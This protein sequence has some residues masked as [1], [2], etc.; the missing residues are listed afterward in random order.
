M[1]ALSLG[2]AGPGKVLT[3]SSPPHS[4]AALSTTVPLTIQVVLCLGLQLAAIQLLYGHD[5]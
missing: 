5:W 3:K 2:Q 4:L 1:L